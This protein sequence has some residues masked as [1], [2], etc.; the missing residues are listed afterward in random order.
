MKTPEDARAWARQRFANQI[1]HWFDGGGEWPLSVSLE[2]PTRSVVLRDV[3]AVKTW[4][5]AWRSWLDRRRPN[6][7]SVDI[8]EIEWPGMGPQ[9]FASRLT[10]ADAST[11]A[12]FVGESVAWE[13]AYERRTR[14]VASWPQLAK[15][16]LGTFYTDLSQEA[17]ADFDR[18]VAL[19]SWFVIHPDSGLYVRQLPVQ[20][21]D[22]KW[23][24]RA[25]R[26]L[27]S[28]LLLRIK[29]GLAS[30][31]GP[32]AGGV[33]DRQA[34]TETVGELSV[35]EEFADGSAT[36]DFYRIC[37]LLRPPTRMR[38]AVLCPELRRQIG[39]VRNLESSVE[40]L[41]QLPMRLRGV[42]IVENLETAYSL[43]DAP[44]VVAV[45]KLG[46]AVSLVGQLPWTRGVPV[47]YWGDVDSYG[48]SILAQARQA[49]E[50]H[51]SSVESVLMDV[52]AVER[53]LHLVVNEPVQTS[54]VDCRWLRPSEIEVYEG[55]LG[56]RWGKQVRI[57]QERIAWPEASALLREWASRLA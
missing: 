46:N 41:V 47:L 3:A 24:D 53:H 37:G 26:W 33:D 9:T 16:G 11:V 29:G 42:V 40:D 18:L 25:R 27:V 56:N 44:G 39:G 34:L 15:S 8:E 55:L 57:E 14:L 17:E 1:R 4:S 5:A 50:P 19:L 43:E 22:T 10:F 12:R 51:G 28:Q 54:R 23:V 38:I 20:G 31:D 13:R 21:V 7:P 52:S 2:R 6:D 45:V 32:Q 30:P 48:F 36:P 35:L 49:L